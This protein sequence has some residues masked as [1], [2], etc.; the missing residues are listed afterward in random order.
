MAVHRGGWTATDFLAGKGPHWR[1]RWSTAWRQIALRRLVLVDALPALRARANAAWE[2]CVRT[3]PPMVWR[4]IMLAFL[5]LRRVPSALSAWWAEFR[6]IVVAHAPRFAE[7]RDGWAMSPPLLVL[8]LFMAGL[9][10]FFVITIVHSRLAPDSRAPSLTGRALAV[11][12][13]REHD[14]ATPRPPRGGA[15]DVIATRNLFDP[16][17]S[18]AKNLG[19][20]VETLPPTAAPALYG[21][22]ISEDTRLAYL[23]DPTTKRILGYKIGDKLAGGQVQ[24]IEPDRVVIL[25]AGGVTEVMLHDATRPLPA[26]SESPQG[27]NE[28]PWRRPVH[29]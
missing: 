24:R 17:R 8:N 15:Y 29:D 5:A 18:D 20:I 7:L 10:V 4:L 22:V 27:T 1:T 19:A 9:S 6:A 2:G 16:N 23:E 25:R 12:A 13:S 14:L 26:V 3:D 21:V 11:A 28:G